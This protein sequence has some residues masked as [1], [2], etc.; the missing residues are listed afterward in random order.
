MQIIESPV[1]GETGIQLQL[2]TC[3]LLWRPV[4][5]QVRFVAVRHPTRGNM[6]LMATDTHLSAREIIE[7]YG[8]RFKIEVSFKSALHVLGAFLYHFWM[9]NMT[10]I[11]KKAKDQYMH[12]KSQDYRDAVRRKLDAYHRF[13]QMGLIA[14]GIMCALATTVPE[15]V[16]GAFGSYF[17]TIRPGI[18]PSEA[19][20]A[21]SLQN[22]LP[23]L[24]ADNFSEPILTKFLREKLDLQQIKGKGLAA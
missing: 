18:A 13:I 12:H 21:I 19:M 4:G 7:L 14:Q 10:P 3:D 9:K 11:T 20:V 15:L 1:Y 8:Y 6:I 23:Y 16:L 2:W 24:F 22:T 5:V 17:R